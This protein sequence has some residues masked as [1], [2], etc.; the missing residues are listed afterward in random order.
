MKTP[1]TGYWT[2]LCNPKEWEIDKKLKARG[3]IFPF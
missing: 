1:P 2:F 3:E